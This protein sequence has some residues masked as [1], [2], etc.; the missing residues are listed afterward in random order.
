MKSYYI[1][2]GELK[3]EE[4]KLLLIKTTE[5]KKEKCIAFL[6]KIHPYDTPEIIVIKPDEVDEKYLRWLS[7]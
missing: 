6:K 4:E 5:S 3:K 7:N 1:R 2:E